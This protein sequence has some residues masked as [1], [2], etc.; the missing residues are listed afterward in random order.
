MID[1]CLIV[2][3]YLKYLTASQFLLIPGVFTDSVGLAVVS[4]ALPIIMAL[5]QN[6]TK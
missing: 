4:A 3:K 5:G 6:P 1:R 2:S